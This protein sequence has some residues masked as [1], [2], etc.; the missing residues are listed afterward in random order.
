MKVKLSCVIGSDYKGNP[1]IKITKD[2]PQVILDVYTEDINLLKSLVG[3]NL[4]L[5][6]D[7]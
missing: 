3:E 2:C 4:T 7:D 5:S 6:N 1:G